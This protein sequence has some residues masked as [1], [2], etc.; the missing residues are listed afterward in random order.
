MTLHIYSPNNLS[1]L[2]S[3]SYILQFLRY[4]QDI[5]KVGDTIE[6]SKIKYM[7][8]LFLHGTG[9]L[10]KD[11]FF[12]FFFYLKMFILIYLRQKRFSS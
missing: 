8:N 6:R 11:I 1:C 2:V 5:L 10:E 9:T 12:V 7:V 4:C 3:T